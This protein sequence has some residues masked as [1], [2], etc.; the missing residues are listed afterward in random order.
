MKKQYGLHTYLLSISLPAVSP[1]QVRP[2]S[3]PVPR[4][5]S[6]STMELSPVPTSQIPAGITSMLSRPTT[7]HVATPSPRPPGTPN[8]TVQP[9]TPVPP[10]SPGLPASNTLALSDNDIQQF[11]RFVR[12]FVVMS[13]IP[14]MEK[15]VMEWNES[16]CNTLGT[17]HCRLLV[18]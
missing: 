14:W 9:G 16:V 7:P 3:S 2:I 8:L 10:R 15:C 18:S 17:A 11:S 13:V 5:P 4:L 6:L 12:E 1:T